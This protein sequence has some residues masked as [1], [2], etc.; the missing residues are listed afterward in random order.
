LRQIDVSIRINLY[1]FEVTHW[2]LRVDVPYRGKVVNA[3]HHSAGELHTSSVNNLSRN[4]GHLIRAML[5]KDA[6]WKRTFRAGKI[7][8]RQAGETFGIIDAIHIGCSMAYCRSKLPRLVSLSTLTPFNAIFGP[9]C[10]S[11]EIDPG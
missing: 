5:T 2:L 11:D 6:R 1:L 9:Y 3:G 7:R 8:L 10:P 4:G